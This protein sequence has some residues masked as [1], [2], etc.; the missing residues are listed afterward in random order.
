MSDNR[1]GH[2]DPIALAERAPGVKWAKVALVSFVTGFSG[3]M[4]PGP[5]LVLVIQ[6][7]LARGDF[8]AMLWLISG[9]ALLELALLFLLVAGL[10][11]VIQKA[12]VR[13]AIGLVGGVALLYMGIDMLRHVWGLSLNLEGG[14]STAYGAVRLMAAGAAVCA[15]NPYF[16]GWWATVGVGQLAHSAPER[17]REYAAF[18]IGHE[19]SDYGWY[20]L[21]ALIIL[22]GRH[23]LNDA[24]YRGLIVF[25]ALIL[26]LLSIAF[27]WTGV[28]FLYGKK[29]QAPKESARSD[30]EG[31]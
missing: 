5:L 9:H 24:I 14:E 6:Q 15:A 21:V 7:T 22:T 23:W 2:R 18:F 25:C 17:K 8:A 30:T 28:G 16:T 20:A 27:I 4:M 19:A 1:S 3:A 31:S 13:G 11:V 29:N 26:I 10:R 12:R